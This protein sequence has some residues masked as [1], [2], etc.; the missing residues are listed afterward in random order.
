MPLFKVLP[1]PLDGTRCYV[2]GLGGN[3]EELLNFVQDKWD[4]ATG[5]ELVSKEAFLKDILRY[6]DSNGKISWHHDKC[7]VLTQNG[8]ELIYEDEDNPAF[9]LA[10]YLGIELPPAGSIQNSNMMDVE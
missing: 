5:V 9:Q 2:I 7:K 6:K 10:G 3:D 4:D 1:F 8:T